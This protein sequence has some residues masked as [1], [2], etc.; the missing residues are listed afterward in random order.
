M[1]IRVP[2]GRTCEELTNGRPCCGSLEDQRACLRHFKAMFGAGYLYQS[3]DTAK[4]YKQ[5]Y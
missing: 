2:L 3:Q 4:R 1:L 5:S